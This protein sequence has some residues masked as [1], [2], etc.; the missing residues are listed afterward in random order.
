[1]NCA[2]FKFILALLFFGSNGVVASHIGLSSIEIVL[3]R[4]F[5]GSV[6]LI[7]IFFLSGRRLTAFS[8]RRDLL[9][10]AVSGVAMASN[11]LF[12]FESF[13]HIGVGL[14]MLINYCGPA[15]VMALSPLLFKERFTW[16]GLAALAAALAGVVLISGQGPREGASLWGLVCAGLSAVSFAVIVVFSKM[17]RQVKGMENATLQLFFT[18]LTVAV[19]V[20][21]RQ[22]FKMDVNAGNLLPIFWIGLVN[23]GLSCYLYFSAIGSLPVQTVA[24]S[25]YLEPLSGVFFSAIFL[26]ERMLPLQI[27]GAALIIGG[28]I[29]GE[30]YKRKSPQ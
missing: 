10:I 12:L 28:T 27:L 4:S 14:G 6:L 5:L 11:W 25:G 3:V 1:M 18:F 17:S 13:V 22:G 26:D 21:L 7:A 24:I 29:F 20:G 23:T 15:L 19:F 30:N 2:Y 16:L 9:C 8:H